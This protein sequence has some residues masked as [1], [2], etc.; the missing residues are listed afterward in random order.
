MVGYLFTTHLSG[1]E[2]YISSSRKFVIKSS[3]TEI[4]EWID[5]VF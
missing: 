5:R 1:F 3:F 4:A 2:T